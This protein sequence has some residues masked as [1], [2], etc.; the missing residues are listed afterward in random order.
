MYWLTS[1]LHLGDTEHYMRGRPFKNPKD[2][3]NLM[4]SNLKKFVGPN[5]ALYVVGDFSTITETLRQLGC[6]LQML[7]V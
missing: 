1:D 6:M 3:D 7:L 2:C 4:L 5:D